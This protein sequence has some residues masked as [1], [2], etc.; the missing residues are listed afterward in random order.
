[1]N[2]KV[3]SRDE[4]ILTESDLCTMVELNTQGGHI[5]VKEGH[6]PY[7]A[8]VYPGWLRVHLEDGSVRQWFVHSGMV[9]VSDNTMEVVLTQIAHPEKLDRQAIERQLEELLKQYA[10]ADPSDTLTNDRL[11]EEIQWCRGRLW[12]LDHQDT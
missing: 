1:M 2:V 5:G 4:G 7:T 6:A 12:L 11:M 10:E 8:V 3:V 9:T